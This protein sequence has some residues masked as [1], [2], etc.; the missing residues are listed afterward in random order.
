MFWK[1]T[2]GVGADTCVIMPA[3]DCS[4]SSVQTVPMRINIFF[5]SVV[6]LLRAGSRSCRLDIFKLTDRCL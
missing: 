2:P 6:K 5:L 3:C 4:K 1:D